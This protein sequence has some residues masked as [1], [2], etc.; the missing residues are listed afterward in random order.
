MQ[1]L[2]TTLLP[3]W[4]PAIT[5]ILATVASVCIAINKITQAVNIMSNSVE[6][7]EL[8]KSLKIQIAQNEE[9][10]RTNKILIDE[11]TKIKGYVDKQKEG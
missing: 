5:A 2:L 6:L 3:I 11:L 4:G 8:V 1:E 10:K 9:L 7:K